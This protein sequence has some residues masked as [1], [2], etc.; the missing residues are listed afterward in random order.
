MV[1]LTQSD[2]LLP[3]LSTRTKAQLLDQH[4]TAKRKATGRSVAADLCQITAAECNEWLRSLPRLE[5]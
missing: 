5:V 4:R 3:T 2:W 1:D